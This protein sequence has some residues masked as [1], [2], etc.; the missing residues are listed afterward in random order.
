[1]GLRKVM[2]KTT[3]ARI[4]LAIPLLLLAACS[5]DMSDLDSYID[6]VNARPARPLEPIPEIEP[7]APVD[8]AAADLRDP[9]VPNEIFNPEETEQNGD[10]S[11]GPRPIAGREKE[12]LEAFPL[13]SLRMVGTIKI[14]A[15]RYGLVRSSEPLIYRVKPGDYLG[16]NH[17]EVM[18]VEPT[19]LALKELFADGAGRWVERETSMGLSNAPGVTK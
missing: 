4:A 13:D 14:G 16:Q 19:R 17:G 7:Y 6:E 5:R 2:S 12:P 3:Y 10:N 15:V 8:Y 18:A 11:S 1:M 9:F